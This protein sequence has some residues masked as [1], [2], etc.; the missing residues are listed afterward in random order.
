M[1][2]IGLTHRTVL[3]PRLFW[4]DTMTTIGLTHRTVLGPRLF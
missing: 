3:G 1:T 2:T 4:R